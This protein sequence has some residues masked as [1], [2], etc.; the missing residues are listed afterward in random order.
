MLVFKRFLEDKLTG[1]LLRSVGILYR[2]QLRLCTAQCAGTG[3]LEKWKN[4]RWIL[5][6]FTRRFVF[7][8]DN[9]E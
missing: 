4:F 3:R 6:R 9:R 1:K 7:D 5:S 2:V 8:I